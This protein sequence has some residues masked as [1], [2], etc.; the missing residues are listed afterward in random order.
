MPAIVPRPENLAPL[1]RT[2][3]R[4]RVLL[5]ADLANLYGVA[6]KALNQAVKRN[7]ERFPADFMFQLTTE[8]WK[9]LRSRVVTSKELRTG[10]RSQFVT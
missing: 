2:I 9:D 1:V 8:E 5:D 4:E 3:R 10:M 6:T 7:L